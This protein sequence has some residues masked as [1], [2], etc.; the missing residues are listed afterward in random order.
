MNQKNIRLS[1]ATLA[2]ALAVLPAV[3]PAAHAQRNRN[4]RANAPVTR[5]RTLAWSSAS[6][7]PKIRAGRE[8]GFYVWHDRNTVHIAS[9]DATR[10]RDIYSGYV[11]IRGRNA[12]LDSLRNEYNE[13]G[14]R[15]KQSGTHRVNFRFDTKQSKDG[16]AFN[17]HDGQTLVF[18]LNRDGH[19]TGRIFYG[20]RQTE[21]FGDP[22]VFNLKR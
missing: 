11:E 12:G 2:A 15:F 13:G 18:H 7:M 20:S 5:T 3:A 1:C 17:L 22:V 9:S 8:T 14:D 4:R 16:F 10:G 6:G 21:A 19:K